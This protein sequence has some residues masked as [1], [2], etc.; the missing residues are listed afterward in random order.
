MRGLRYR[1][2]DRLLESLRGSRGYRELFHRVFDFLNFYSVRRLLSVNINGVVVPSV[3]KLDALNL[4]PSPDSTFS[5]YAYVWDWETFGKTL[6]I[7]QDKGVG[8]TAPFYLSSHGYYE[9]SKNKC[10]FLYFMSK[11]GEILVD[12]DVSTDTTEVMLV[13]A[14]PGTS[15]FTTDGSILDLSDDT[16]RLTAF[17][18][19]YISFSNSTVVS[20]DISKDFYSGAY[21]LSDE[22]YIDSIVKVLSNVCGNTSVARFKEELL[23]RGMN[24]SKV[25]YSFNNGESASSDSHIVENYVDVRGTNHYSTASKSVITQDGVMLSP[26][27]VWYDNYEMYYQFVL[28]VGIPPIEQNAGNATL[29]R[30]TPWGSVSADTTVRFYL[31]FYQE[32]VPSAEVVNKVE[33]PYSPFL[34][35]VNDND[36]QTLRATIL[37][38]P[39]IA[40]FQNAPYQFTIDFVEPS[41]STSTYFDIVFRSKNYFNVYFDTVMDIT[42]ESNVPYISRYSSMYY[43]GNMSLFWNISDNMMPKLFTFQ[44]EDA[45]GNV[46]NSSYT[47][48]FV[49][50]NGVNLKNPTISMPFSLTPS[51]PKNNGNNRDDVGKLALCSQM[52]VEPNTNTFPTMKVWSPYY[53]AFVDT[54]DAPT[55]LSSSS[56]LS[57]IYSFSISGNSLASELPYVQTENDENFIKFTQGSGYVGDNTYTLKSFTDIFTPVSSSSTN[58]M[59]FGDGNIVLFI[60]DQ[61][62]VNPY[63]SFLKTRQDNDGTLNFQASDGTPTT[64]STDYPANYYRNFIAGTYTIPN[65]TLSYNFPS[66][67]GVGTAE[68]PDR[69]Y[70]KK[71]GNFPYQFFVDNANLSSIVFP[72]PMSQG[73]YLHPAHYEVSFD[74]R[75][76]YSSELLWL[77]F[78]EPAPS[79][80]TEYHSHYPLGNDVVTRLLIGD[81]DASC[82]NLVLVAL[83]TDTVNSVTYMYYYLT[84]NASTPNYTFNPVTATSFTTEI[85][86]TP[87]YYPSDVA[88]DFYRYAFSTDYMDRRMSVKEVCRCL[89]TTIQL[90]LGTRK[91]GY[92]DTTKLPSIFQFFIHGFKESVTIQHR[93]ASRYNLSISSFNSTYLDKLSSGFELTAR[94]ITIAAELGLVKPLVL[95]GAL[96]L[97]TSVIATIPNGKCMAHVYKLE[98][99]N[100]KSSET[101]NRDTFKFRYASLRFNETNGDGSSTYPYVGFNAGNYDVRE[102]YYPVRI[103]SSSS[104]GTSYYI[105]HIK[106]RPACLFNA[107]AGDVHLYPY[108]D[109]QRANFYGSNYLGRL[110]TQQ[111]MSFSGSGIRPTSM[112]VSKL[113]SFSNGVRPLVFPS[114]S[115]VEDSSEVFQNRAYSVF[116]ISEISSLSSNVTSAT[117]TDAKSFIDMIIDGFSFNAPD[118]QSE[119]RKRVYAYNDFNTSFFNKHFYPYSVQDIEFIPILDAG[120]DSSAATIRFKSIYNNA[121]TSSI[122]TENIL[123][124]DKE[125]LLNQKVPLSYFFKS[126]QMYGQSNELIAMLTQRI[127]SLGH[128]S[129]YAITMGELTFTE[130]SNP[131]ILRTDMKLTGTLPIDDTEVLDVSSY[132]VDLI[133]VSCQRIVIQGIAHTYPMVSVGYSFYDSDAS[134]TKSP[135]FT[136]NFTETR[137]GTRPYFVYGEPYSLNNV[138][139]DSSINEQSASFQNFRVFASE[140]KS[141]T[142][143]GAY[144]F[145]VIDEDKWALLSTFYRQTDDINS[146]SEPLTAVNSLDTI[147][148]PDYVYIPDNT[149]VIYT[150]IPSLNGCCSMYQG[151]GSST[152]NNQYYHFPS[153][154]YFSFGG[155]SQNTAL[156]I[157]YLPSLPMYDVSAVFGQYDSFGRYFA[158]PMTAPYT[159]CKINDSQERSDMVRLLLTFAQNWVGLPTMDEMLKPEAGTHVPSDGL[160]TPTLL[161]YYYTADLCPASISSPYALNCSFIS[162][163]TSSATYDASHFSDFLFRVGFHAYPLANGAV[164][165]D[166]GALLY[167]SGS[168]DTSRGTLY[169]DCDDIEMYRQHYQE[170]SPYIGVNPQTPEGVSSDDTTRFT[171]YQNFTNSGI[172]ESFNGNE[173]FL[174]CYEQGVKVDFPNDFDPERLSIERRHSGYTWEIG[175]SLD[176]F[177]SFNAEQSANGQTIITY[178]EFVEERYGNSYKEKLTDFYESF[179]PMRANLVLENED[180]TAISSIENGGNALNENLNTLGGG[181]ADD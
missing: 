13:F 43:L 151:S 76:G 156:L 11:T 181:G 89:E 44:F 23:Q 67:D 1:F 27:D 47:P 158:Y 125:M 25:I 120:E 45:D 56:F 14:Q 92:T 149:S 18:T 136:I 97:N 52:A 140:I 15:Q 51:Y 141:G 31:D 72:S 20:P 111:D 116:S 40:K 143:D 109:S 28:H 175:K 59:T 172:V 135:Q 34:D 48:G 179:T 153:I 117:N 61:Y 133:D 121:I 108:T 88:A 161:A 93:P 26:G 134:V 10:Y 12:L 82:T 5:Q 145:N 19:S 174:S 33:L 177:V 180:G 3:L 58:F 69:T 112:S 39:S 70:F 49:V 167:D 95:G 138:N 24:N 17:S 2:F 84:D 162:P 57:K 142:Y 126:A 60:S 130:Q 46:F 55:C 36:F 173:A 38:L 71:L 152:N 8:L 80:G 163:I 146:Q 132:A 35:Y 113:D 150:F 170:W 104:L 78:P 115:Y 144:T 118:T 124:T 101:T 157:A 122:F 164:T 30:H 87:H 65:G 32:S 63:L 68:N 169:S 131:I 90:Y 62:Q 29:K 148:V 168:F 73:Y 110:F 107:N 129:D 94:P 102:F 178:P 160:N 75:R 159:P 154:Y 128:N 41:G 7:D 74:I 9:A 119:R 50:D 64:Y 83:E 127:E 21:S 22:T 79:Y 100:V 6:G 137:A 77:S 105:M 147:A 66:A 176:A 91:S 37:A 155:D 53:V 139:G 16:T 54:I 81:Y 114:V 103:S 166:K 165:Q 123:M 42:Y 96:K 98:V 86:N 171:F 99:F 85:D 4:T 106:A